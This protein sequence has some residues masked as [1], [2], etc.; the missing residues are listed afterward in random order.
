[1]EA[2]NVTGMLILNG[3]IASSTWK[4][5]FLWSYRNPIEFISLSL[6][7]MNEGVFCVCLE[8]NIEITID[9]A[10]MRLW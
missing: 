8:E 1:M 5:T 10:T 6:H 7:Y 2:R 3:S 9:I 4:R